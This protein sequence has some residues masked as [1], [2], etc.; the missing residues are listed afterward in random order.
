[1]FVAGDKIDEWRVFMKGPDRTPYANKWWY[2]FVTFPLAYPQEPPMFRFISVPFHVNISPEGRICLNLLEK[3]YESNRT[4]F[5]LLVCIQALL[6]NPNYK[7]PIDTDRRR[8][9]DTSP[10][11]FEMR[12]ALSAQEFAKDSVEAWLQYLKIE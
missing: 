7:D 5:G 10:G 4:V 11:E 12:G 6:Q 3:E 2:V 1:V 8:L 9:A